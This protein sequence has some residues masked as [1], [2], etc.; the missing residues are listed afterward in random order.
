MKKLLALVLA[1]AALLCCLAACDK[2]ERDP[3]YDE[4][5]K[6]EKGKNYAIITLNDFPVQENV[7]FELPRTGL[8]EGA[9]Y[10]QINLEEGALSISYKDNILN[11]AQPLGEFTADDEMPINGSGGYVEGDKIT[12]V[13]E[14]LS[15]VSG[16]IIIAF[17]EDALK[18]VH[19]DLTL[20]EHTGEWYSGEEA[21][22]YQYT[23]G[24]ESP[25]IAE[26][27]TDHDG[28]RIC[29][30][31]GYVMAD[32]EH[33]YEKYNDEIGHGWS[34]TC[35]CMTPPN[36]AQ[37][38]DGDGDDKCDTC[39]Y[40]ML[41]EENHFLRNQAGTT[42][43]RD[44]TAEDI[45]K[46]KI[47]SQ[48]GMVAAGCLKYISSS[49]NKDTI[50]RMF[51]SYYWLNMKPVD[52]EDT[53][54]CDGGL[55]T[56][57]FIMND[58]SV[59]KITFNNGEFFTD[60][61]QN[62]FELFNLPVFTDTDKYRNYY[63]FETD[64]GRGVVKRVADENNFELICEIPMDEIEFEYDVDLDLPDLEPYDIIVETD[65]GDLKFIAPDIFFTPDGVTCV[66]VGMNLDE[67]II[68]YSK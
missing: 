10:Y 7:S 41:P 26:L 27:H 34:Y 35:G 2:F 30:T 67:L 32:H 6:C 8:G 52:E 51:E 11:S 40:Y 4:S 20:H 45:S 61:D 43:I 24:C 53:I 64:T 38:Y 21:H 54:V 36:F 9:I 33:S 63:A 44:I 14:S 15:P 56:V 28:N 46:I 58:G 68:E 19:K 49:V 39:G 55:V 66:L 42:W 23:C 17:T 18:A 12:I 1:L 59:K 5:I 48:D 22:W 3:V 65:F 57:C 50:A 60:A 25:D 47:I 13:F 62:H 37:H 16:E 31:C 29:D